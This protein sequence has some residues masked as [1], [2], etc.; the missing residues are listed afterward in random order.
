M[1]KHLYLEKLSSSSK[2]H[3]LTDS[4]WKLLQVQLR[5]KWEPIAKVNRVGEIWWRPLELN[6]FQKWKKKLEEE[7]NEL[8]SRTLS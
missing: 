2:F 1:V 4:S 8:Q 5:K 7:A 3:H 6:T